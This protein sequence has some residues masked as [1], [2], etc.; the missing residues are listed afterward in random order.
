MAFEG[1][2]YRDD[3][4]VWSSQRLTLY[5]LR[6]SH[7]GIITKKT[8]IG[9]TEVHAKTGIHI[10]RLPLPPLLL[11]ASKFAPGTLPQPLQRS[12]HIRKLV[13]QPHPCIIIRPSV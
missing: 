12:P 8:R 7:L 3:V 4:G 11:K 6:N 10:R 2:R 5:V 9:R 13:L 1:K